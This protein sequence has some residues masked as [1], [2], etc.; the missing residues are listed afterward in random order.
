MKTTTCKSLDSSA[1]SG[2]SH[3]LG[4]ETKYERTSCTT[5]HARVSRALLQHIE[6][7][8]NREP[9]IMH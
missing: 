2:Q 9:M 8:L 6:W 1:T 3:S 7:E 4:L 5:W